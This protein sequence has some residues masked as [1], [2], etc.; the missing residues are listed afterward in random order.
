VVFWRLLYTA[1]AIILILCAANISM[2]YSCIPEI[3]YLFNLHDSSE[4]LGAEY[5]ESKKKCKKS[6]A[7][8]KCYIAI[9]KKV[10][11]S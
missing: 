2:S 4:Y 7:A 6:E 11:E 10:S 5:H 9:P 8:Q 3:S 1:K